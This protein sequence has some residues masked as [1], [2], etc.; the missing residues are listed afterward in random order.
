MNRSLLEAFRAAG[1][2]LA[3]ALRTQRNLR[4]H[5]GIGAVVAALAWWLDADGAQVALL[6][7]AIALVVTSELFNTSIEVLTDAAV[8]NRNAADEGPPYGKIVK[9][10]AAGAVAIAAGA[11]AAI[12]VVVLGPS[13]L[14]RL[15][16]LDTAWIRGITLGA[17]VVAGVLGASWRW[18]TDR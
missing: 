8:P 15:G 6:T 9:D 5:L 13:I 3:H 14:E 10:I 2:G 17:M 16:V 1:S 12:G 7:V 11:A 4:L 18:V